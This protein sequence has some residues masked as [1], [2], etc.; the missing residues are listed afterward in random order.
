MF[1]TLR[2]HGLFYFIC[3]LF[4]SVE[5][6]LYPLLST[7]SLSVWL[8]PST[9]IHPYWSDAKMLR[10]L[11]TEKFDRNSFSI[12]PGD[13]GKNSAKFVFFVQN[14]LNFWGSTSVPQ[15]EVSSN[16]IPPNATFP[17]G[18]FLLSLP[19]LGSIF[20]IICRGY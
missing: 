9:K 2:S 18:S 3:S 19:N 4:L 6:Y 20:F 13:D 7:S 16:D 11:K 17:I 8:S 12:L 5:L 14:V 15:R 1:A 10:K